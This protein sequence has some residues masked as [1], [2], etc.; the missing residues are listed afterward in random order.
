MRGLLLYPAGLF[1]GVV[2]TTVVWIVI[3]F[4]WYQ[5]IPMPQRHAV[6]GGWTYLLNNPWVV[7]LLTL[8]FGIGFYLVTLL[9]RLMMR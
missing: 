7:V 4:F 5:S 1:G 3:V 9:S 2:L 8:G 6:A